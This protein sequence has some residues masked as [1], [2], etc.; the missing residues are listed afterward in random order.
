M[1][2]ETAE[3]QQQRKAKLAGRVAQ[4]F[5]LGDNSEPE[6]DSD[7]DG[8]WDDD[9]LLLETEVTRPAQRAAGKEATRET[10]PRA[11]RMAMRT[12]VSSDLG[13]RT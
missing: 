13:G 7:E 9:C 1:Q 6:M 5:H 10:G 3:Q 12:G 4:A 8:D 2:V 11:L